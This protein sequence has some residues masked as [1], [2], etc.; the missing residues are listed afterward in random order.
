MFF[1]ASYTNSSD[2][3]LLGNL[4]NRTSRNRVLHHAFSIV[5]AFML[6]GVTDPLKPEDAYDTV[7]RTLCF[8]VGSI[9]NVVIL[10]E[11]QQIFYE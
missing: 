3:T 11:F 4:G 10:G 6:V 7:F 2:V 1:V 5:R 9:L 8:I